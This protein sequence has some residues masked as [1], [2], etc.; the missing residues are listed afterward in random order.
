MPLGECFHS[1]SEPC[2]LHRLCV[3]TQLMSL[4]LWCDDSLSYTHNA[5][6]RILRL[7]LFKT[8]TSEDIKLP[9]P[10]WPVQNVV[11]ACTPT[12]RRRSQ[13][14]REMWSLWNEEWR[15]HAVQL[16]ARSVSDQNECYAT[17]WVRKRTTVWHR[18]CGHFSRKL[19]DYSGERRHFD[20][21][22]RPTWIA[23]LV[24]F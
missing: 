4:W 2:S 20:Q 7:D 3:C 12:R 14:C 10:S 19:E 15:S 9:W 11:H 22:S 13:C 17:N 5:S 18:L 16:I 6:M 8:V 24:N 21:L 1:C 23:G